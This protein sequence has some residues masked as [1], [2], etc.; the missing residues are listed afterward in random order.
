MIEKFP[1]EEKNK[2]MKLITITKNKFKDAEKLLKSDNNLR[3][4]Y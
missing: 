1:S 3:S 2:S 4:V